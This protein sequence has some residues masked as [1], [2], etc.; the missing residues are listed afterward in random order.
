M[1]DPSRRSTRFS[2]RSKQLGQLLIENGDVQSEQIAAALETQEQQGGLLGQILQQQGVCQPQAIAAAL[3]KQV[4]VTDVKCEDLAVAHDVASLIAREFCEAERLCP[5]ELLGSQ[6]LCIVMGNP[7]NRRAIS[8]IEQGTHFKVK[9]FKSTW[10]K[11]NELIQRTYDGAPV[12]GDAGGEQ[13]PQEEL[14]IDGGDA[15][16]S[17]D[18][19]PPPEA[20]GGE[21]EPL[22]LDEPVQPQEIPQAAPAA[23]A[24]SAPAQARA[25]RREPSAEIKI[26][27]FEN[28]DESNAEVIETNRRGL[29][30]KPR[31]ATPDEVAPRPKAA[32]VA[33]VN[34]NLDELD[35]HAG[36][37]VKT[38]GIDDDEQL[39]EIA[40]DGV[41][42]PVPLKIVHDSYFYESGKSP[43]GER[44]NE[45]QNLILEIACADTVAQSIGDLREQRAEEAQKKAG[46]PKAA[47]AVSVVS[48]AN[49]DRP[50]ELQPCPATIMAA[51][52]IPEIEFQ[53]FVAKLGEDPVGE[54]DWQFAAA[55]PIPVSDYEE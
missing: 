53:R 24:P 17:L 28:L 32:K 39:E 22:Q 3:L 33:K 21:P 54:W 23:R 8:Q 49:T 14:A 10:P 11:I 15:G 27:G 47:V 43:I 29:S 55:G 30:A 34:I 40:H 5:F 18:M 19:P 31:S 35:I 37:V 44:S 25:P 16:P 46:K 13:A 12:E 9:S 26:K 52:P 51:V 50:L 2:M 36:E 45:L 1:A 41:N 6:L 48:A 7:L 42:H 38:G 20:L 4:Q